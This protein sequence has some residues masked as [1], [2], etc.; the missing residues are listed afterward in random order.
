MSKEVDQ[1]IVEMQ[2][3]NADFE[4]KVSKSINS[5]KQL[6]DASQMEDAGKGLENL[7]KGVHQLDLSSIADGIEKLN[8]RFSNLGIVGMTVMQNL[9]N[10]AM[11]LGNQLINA[12]TEAPR[13]G[14]QTYESFISA[15]KQLKNSAKDAEGLPV[16]LDAVNKA[17]DELN[18]YSDK[19][20][21]SFN[22]MTANIGKFTNAG[23]S[24]EDSVTAIKGISN[25]AASAGANAQNAAAAMYNFGQALGTG[26]VKLVDWKSI[27]NANMGTIEFKEQLIQTAKEL[28]TLKEVGDR[29]IATTYS[30]KKANEEAFNASSKFEDSLQQQWM[31][32]EV[33]IKTLGKYANEMDP[34]GA[35][36]Y[37][38]ATEVNSFTQMMSVFAESQKTSWSKTWR[39]IFGDYEESKQLWTGI[40]NGLNWMTDGF[41]KW[42]NEFFKSWHDL[43]GRNE[44]FSAFANIWET[45]KFYVEKIGSAVGPIFSSI[46]ATPLVKIAEGFNAATEKIKPIKE[47]VEQVTDKIGETAEAVTDVADRAE[48]FNEIVQEIIRGEWGN[49]Q[50]RID[51]LHEAGYAFENLQNAVNELLGCEKRY[52]TVM[53]D[54]EAIG[55]KV[56]DVLEENAQLAEN[57]A[58]AV[59]QLTESTEEAGGV[60]GNLVKIL[61]AVKSV[62]ALVGKGFGAV[63]SA[64]GKG[65]FIL[66]TLKAGLKFVLDI[67]GGIAGKIYEFTSW[68]SKFKSL[69]TFVMGLGTAIWRIGDRLGVSLTPLK[70]LLY[71]IASVMGKVKKALSDLL[72]PLK[73]MD[74]SG[75]FNVLLTILKAVAAIAGGVLLV[76]LNLVAAAINTVV[77]Y[78]KLLWGTIKNLSIVKSI[79]E[80]FKS[81]KAEL[82]GYKD[83][84]KQA[85]AYTDLFAPAMD[86]VAKAAEHLK[87]LFGPIIQRAFDAFVLYAIKAANA[88]DALYNA[89]KNSKTWQSF[90]N[91]FLKFKLAIKDIP[92]LIA[93]VFESIQKNGKLPELKDL[94]NS[95]Q[96]LVVAF[97]NF[98]E[99]LTGNFTKLF[100]DLMEKFKGG[101]DMLGK[102]NFGPFQGLVDNLKSIFND[103][104]KLVL[105]GEGTIGQLITNVW[106]KLSKIDFRGGAIT[107]LIGAVALFAVRWSKVGK[108][109][110]FA[111]KGLGHFFRNGGQVATTAVDKFNGFLKI[112]AAIAIIAG[113][114]W[115]IAE[116]PADRFESAVGTI[117]GAFAVMFGAIELLAYQKI[118]EDKMKA[119]G[120]AFIGLGAGLAMVAVA[121][122]IF[123]G[124]EWEEL[125][126][127][128]AALVAFTVMVVAAAR[129]AKGVG[130]GAGIAF[131]GLSAAL[132]LLI[133]SIKLLAGMD[134]HTL[135]K[136]GVAVF[137]FVNILAKAANRAGKA[138]GAFG[139]FM[140]LSLALLLL[141]P[142][143]KILSGMD[144]GTLI[145]G[146]IAVYAFLNIMAGAAKKAQGGARGFLGMGIA[147]G[148]LA[149]SLKL[150]STIPW[151][152]L[153]SVSMSLRGV[154]KTITESM[155]S[156][157]K[158]SWGGVLKTVVALALVLGAVG[159]AL[160]LL[161]KFTDTDQLLKAALGVSAIL[162][163]FSFMGPTIATLSAI[164]FMAG[165]QAALNAMMFF[166]AMILCLEVLGEVA[167]LG[168]GHVGE[169]I[170]SG[171]ATLGRIIHNFLDGLRHGD[172]EEVSTQ[173]EKTV[174]LAD[175]LSAFGDSIQGFL[176]TLQD[177]DYEVID[178]AKA[179]A[180]AILTIT[181]ADLVDA[182][183]G[184]IRGEAGLD[185]F[186]NSI[187]P[188]TEAV[189]TMNE[190]LENV[191]IDTSKIDTV[192]SVVNSMA[193][194][195]KALPKK[196]G[197]AQKILGVQELATFAKDMQDFLTNGFR[198]FVIGVDHLGEFLNFGLIAKIGII[199]NVTKV[200]IDLAKSLPEN[201]VISKFIDGPK[202]LGKFAANMCSFMADEGGF[203]DFAA[204]VNG[205]TTG[206]NLEMLRGNIIPATEEMIKL[207]TKLKEGSSILD[208]I[209]GRTDL[210]KFGERLAA[211]GEG[212]NQFSASIVNVK[213]DHI[214]G[215][216]EAMERLAALNASENLTTSNLG[217]FSSSI[218]ALGAAIALF[219]TDTSA[220]DPK[221]IDHIIGQIA[222]LHNLML[223]LTASQYDVSNFAESLRQLGETSAKS[224]IESFTEAASDASEA[225]KGL[226]NSFLSGIDAFK[227]DIEWKGI[228]VVVIFSMAIGAA[229]DVYVKSI[230]KTIIT[231]LGEGVDSKKTDI[232]NMGMR[233]VLEFCAGVSGLNGING[234]D[235]LLKG[236]GKHMVD[237]AIEGI[238]D[239]Q[240]RFK[241]QG[242][243]SAEGYAEGIRDMAWEAAEEAAQMV[244]DAAQAAA[245]AQ[246]S[247]SPS[248]V[249]MGLGKDGIDGYILGFV[250]NTSRV[251][252]A[253]TSVG[254]AGISAMQKTIDKTLSL[255]DGNLDYEPTI[256]PVIDLSELT[257]GVQQANMLLSDIHTDDLA[258]TTAASIAN[259]HNEAIAVRSTP[260]VNYSKDLS[261][262]IEN[263]NRIINAVKQ[264]RYAV[265]DGDEAFRFFDRRLGMA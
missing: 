42:R 12:L 146:G 65:A 114:I 228:S 86:R 119:I 189:I 198:S 239:E 126:K 1:R 33:L 205:M 186:S 251:V 23:V 243:Y 248:K 229:A 129:A 115:L 213:L 208:F 19:T 40:L 219:Y 47:E 142:S 192:V 106:G 165:A 232:Q 110:S 67:L 46:D 265:I 74:P 158:V 247:A 21:Y 161:T 244:R 138:K 224:F 250:K 27:N 26:V 216:T 87:E 95:F 81:F 54:N 14:M 180:M 237:K 236:A 52:E 107:A 73:G 212:I 3:N 9:T 255:V 38:A 122:K 200:M 32:S 203:Q 41:N 194:L 94:P 211:F 178:K 80:A 75:V 76:S 18:N 201:G 231:K 260:T 117:A 207:G 148:I 104:K 135:I 77:K 130:K 175:K 174:T 98:K 53:S 108:S 263:T 202:D 85:K 50:E 199:Q 70:E 93:T 91:L 182:L 188:L 253:V 48:K 125:K 164:P 242:N 62:T 238:E 245:A 187:V 11:N 128:G 30:G 145:K 66:D 58:N 112:A 137:A 233:V 90:T 249:Y 5:L 61:L 60:V 179:L 44:L 150:L 214:N 141:I 162:L 215:M 4:Q 241:K 69:Q 121:A 101:F 131:L 88:F 163:A 171:S 25:V 31:T 16:T 123:A 127:G 240:D 96:F 51:R 235:G 102:V 82:K 143:I 154:L 79:A 196:G 177:T 92:E 72:E 190:K 149:L 39:Y 144:A 252:K 34:I 100:Q 15:T 153:L 84:L 209:T 226:M 132:L 259:A 223:I 234:T 78:T 261:D 169:M 8:A 111:L 220:A 246:D 227:N 56:G 191:E 7:T 116:I 136:G 13:G 10:A 133:P 63:W 17:L 204:A 167:S 83:Q 2:F 59:D 156:I 64:L 147:I 157:S 257:T 262:L 134:A 166:G 103:L 118:P 99:V 37:Q 160:Y 183:A 20:I 6:K 139:A 168:D 222:N 89:A 152:A 57:Q 113:S 254:K 28:G 210:G 176:K 218:N 184:W 217:T 124:M 264:N 71:N 45:V 140:G 181:A 256:T 159:G 22:D 193:D 49:G 206:V 151:S 258:A 173:A 35:K 120:M 105:E 68:A 170:E 29:Y 197:W 230:G 195:A 155:V 225:A 109:A 43:G 97:N 24:L 36:A 185:E 172:G 55:I 221:A